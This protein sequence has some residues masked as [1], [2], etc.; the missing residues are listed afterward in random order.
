MKDFEIKKRP[1]NSGFL[2]VACAVNVAIRSTAQRV[3]STATGSVWWHQTE[4]N[5]HKSQCLAAVWTGSLEHL[6]QT[7]QGLT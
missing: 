2:F 6:L 7:L 4:H 5:W 3:L 1:I